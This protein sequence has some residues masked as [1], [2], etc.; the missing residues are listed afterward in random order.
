MGGGVNP[1]LG[2]SFDLGSALS[3]GGEH[4]GES[5]RGLRLT[6]NGENNRN[7]TYRNERTDVKER[8]QR[9]G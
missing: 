9:A 2:P 4:G 6:E 5:A 3:C 1:G 8:K 7:G